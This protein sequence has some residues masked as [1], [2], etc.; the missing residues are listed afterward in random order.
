MAY[1]QAMRDQVRSTYIYKGLPLKDTAKLNGIR[2]QTAL[3]WRKAALAKGDD[4]DT[5]RSAA[6]MAS[7]GLTEINNML[8]ENFA[9]HAE[10]ILE[11]LRENDDVTPS[12]KADIMTKL[13]DAHSKMVATVAKSGTKIAPLAVAMTV[14]KMLT[15]FIKE[16]YPEHAVSFMEILEPFGQKVA[17]DIG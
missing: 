14:L 6:R 7:G 5:A 10:S 3:A 4:W 17:K 9:L 15:E 13:A 2:Y 11:N 8:L 12:S 1:P 16:N